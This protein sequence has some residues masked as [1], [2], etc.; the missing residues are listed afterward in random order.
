[1]SSPG[2]SFSTNR[3]TLSQLKKPAMNGESKQS[4]AYGKTKLI[5]KYTLGGFQLTDLVWMRPADGRY[6]FEILVRYIDPEAA[7]TKRDDGSY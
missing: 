2:F 5:K 3:N 7:K 1:M 4:V 6:K